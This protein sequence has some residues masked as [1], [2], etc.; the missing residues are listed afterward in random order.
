MVKQDMPAGKA[1]SLSDGDRTLSAVAGSLLL[2]FVARKHKVNSLLFLGGGYLLYRAISGECPV[3]AA[4]KGREKG[5]RHM[6]NVNIRTHV[7]V[8]KPREQVYALWRNLKNLPL[9]MTHL[10]MVDEID[11]ERSSW[12]LRLPS[13]LGDLHWDARIVKDEKDVELSWHSEEGSVIENTGKVNFSDTPGKGTRVDIMLSYRAAN[14][15]GAVRFLTPALRER[16]EDDIQ[17]FKHYIENS[18][19]TGA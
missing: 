3:T 1:V 15:E 11:S 12:R 6:S 4:L 13:G 10:D 19:E 14:G 2:Y 16:I 18:G 17:N 7:I 5:A 8:N 9:F